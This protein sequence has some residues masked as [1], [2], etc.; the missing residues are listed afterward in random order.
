MSNK[1]KQIIQDIKACEKDA[2]AVSIIKE[3]MAALNMSQDAETINRLIAGLEELSDKFEQLEAAYKEIETPKD[4]SEV[5]K[6]RTEANFIYREIADD[7]V[8]DVSRLRT[9]FEELK[10]VERAKGLNELKEDE[11]YS[12]IGKSYLRDYL[13]AAENYQE[14]MVSY[15]LAYGAYSKM[16]SLMDSIR[17]FTD[18][19]AGEIRSLQQVEI[20]DAK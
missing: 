15:S 18:S 19:L 7:Y 17:M 20:K 16:R 11:R 5:Q 12:N 8:F 1:A 6:I 14:W 3:I 2:D 13:G 4:I 10:T 9:L